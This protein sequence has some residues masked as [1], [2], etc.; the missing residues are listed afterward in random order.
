M[1]A[2]GRA[3][4]G[5][6][7]DWAEG[8]ETCLVF[9]L[10]GLWTAVLRTDLPQ[11]MPMWASKPVQICTFTKFQVISGDIKFKFMM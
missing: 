6:I 11:V 9:G 10:A 3:K 5:E 1:S 4:E 8:W 7:E 2:I